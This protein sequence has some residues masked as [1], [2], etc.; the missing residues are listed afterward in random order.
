M[1]HEKDCS[2]DELMGM[3]IAFANNVRITPKETNC[4]PDDPM[5][6]MSIIKR[7]SGQFRRGITVMS[8]R[9]ASPVDILERQ[10]EARDGMDL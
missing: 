9:N 1:L 5:G 2:D 4:W 3:S 10:N 8:E 6:V 7:S